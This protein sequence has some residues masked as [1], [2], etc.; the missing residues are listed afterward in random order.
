MTNQLSQRI[1]TA[2][3][4]IALVAGLVALGACGT[5]KGAAE[6]ELSA[7]A[8]QEVPA[9]SAPSTQPPQV[10]LANVASPN[11][12]APK[13]APPKAAPPQAAPSPAIAQEEKRRGYV[14]YLVHG[15]KVK[16]SLADTITRS[17]CGAGTRFKLSPALLLAIMAVESSYDPSAFNGTD[18][19]LMQVNPRAHP[20]KVAKVGGDEALYDVDNNIFVGAWALREIRN[21]SKS[22]PEALLRYAG[23]KKTEST[24]AKRV[25]THR[26]ALEHAS[27]SSGRAEMEI[28]RA[29]TIALNIPRK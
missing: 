21:R 20:E 19:G 10:A 12:A 16:A 6:P 23:A 22:M 17:A 5:F 27:Q 8:P 25:E 13:G 4:R 14:R 3:R 26:L 11:G 29:D 9:A 15:F 2:S 18:V 28:G 24:Y 7:S 1:V